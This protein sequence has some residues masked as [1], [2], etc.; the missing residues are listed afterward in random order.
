MKQSSPKFILFIF[1]DDGLACNISTYYIACNIKPLASSFDIWKNE[2]DYYVGLQIKGDH[3]HHLLYI[4]QQVYIEHIIKKF[5][6]LDANS[7]LVPMDPN[8]H[9]SLRVDVDDVD[10]TFP[11]QEIMGNL[12]FA[13]FGTWLDPFMLC[14]M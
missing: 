1:V 4:Y 13:S 14:L 12:A 11:Y 5:G 7:M 9:N 10:I 6:F 8:T 3:F 2:L